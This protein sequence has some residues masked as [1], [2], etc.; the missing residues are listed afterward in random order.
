MY[1]HTY[2]CKL[3]S[4]LSLHFCCLTIP[5][6]A[7]ASSHPPEN[8]ATTTSSRY[9]RIPYSFRQLLQCPTSP[10]SPLTPMSLP[11][12]C[13]TRLEPTA[14]HGNRST[15]A[16]STGGHFRQGGT[17]SA[18]SLSAILGPAEPIWR[19]GGQIPHDRSLQSLRMLL[20]NHRSFQFCTKPLIFT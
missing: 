12:A 4:S 3:H 13:A 11:I 20:V 18:P 5:H 6:F 15:F 2:I 10:R 17:I 9:P 14:V 19:E 8:R 16:N 1:V 7:V